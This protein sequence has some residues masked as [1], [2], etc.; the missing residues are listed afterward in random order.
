M[1]YDF[2]LTFF[3]ARL[4]EAVVEEEKRRC[5]CDRTTGAPLSKSLRASAPPGKLP[6]MKKKK[7]KKKKK[8]G[9]KKK[10]E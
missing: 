4:A 1:F 9:R 3:C 6:R 2:R 7:R 8:K 10:R 5:V